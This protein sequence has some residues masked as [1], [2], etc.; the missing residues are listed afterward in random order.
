MNKIDYYTHKLFDP[1]F[2]HRQYEQDLP[3]CGGYLETG[4]RAALIALPFI[5]LYK[6]VG[7]AISLSMGSIRVLSNGMS[8]VSSENWTSCSYRASQ[9]ALATLALVGTLYHFTLGLYLTT[10]VDILSNLASMLQ[11]LYSLEGKEAGSDFLQALSSSL[12]LAIMMTG[13]LE[14]VVASLLIQASVSFLSASDEWKEGRMPEAFAKTLMG[15]IRL[16]Q[17]DQQLEMIGRRDALFKQY[18][19]IVRRIEKGRDVDHLYDHPAVN[20]TATIFEDANGEEHDFGAHLHG[21]GK[22]AV[23]GMNIFFREEGDHTTLEFKVNHVFRDRIRDVVSKF[24]SASKE[25]LQD[26]MKIYGSHSDGISVKW[27]KHSLTDDDWFFDEFQENRMEINFNGLGKIEVG[28]SPEM[29]NNYDIVSVQMEKGKTLYDFHEALAF[30]DLEDALK[31]SGAEDIERLK[32]GQLF[33]TFFPREALPFERSDPFFDLPLEDF[34]EEMIKRAPKMEKI[35]DTWLPKMELREMLPGKMRW[36]IDGLS[37]LLEKQGV[38]GLTAAVT[39]GWW[40]DS[41][42]F[43]KVASML[44]MGMMSHEL[45]D[46]FGIDGNGLSFGADYLTGGADAVYTQLVTD[47]NE[48]FKEFAYRSPIRFMISPKILETGT[49]QYHSDNFGDRTV[50]SYDDFWWRFRETYAERENILDF[51]KSERKDFNSDNEVMIKD[52]IPPEYITGI[53][54]KNEST[55][56]LLLNFLRE[57]NIIQKDSAGIETIFSKPIEEFIQTTFSSSSSKMSAAFGSI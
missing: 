40:S 24:G 23:K 44:K 8:A 39:G 48:S 35:I 41:D 31:A 43:E 19:E 33:R 49:Y 34:K 5:S 18:E 37:D 14:V 4:K 7:S 50:E 45:R 42:Q 9:T 46:R 6:P 11:H 28:S 27:K 20:R 13:S 29:V 30:L 32:L 52:R 16:Y 57:R 2:Y 56:K 36:S 47:K 25:D 21:Y 54:V 53:I 38:R 26:L 51:A 22:G 12:Y 10:G 1:S 3:E 15:M 17:A 55:K